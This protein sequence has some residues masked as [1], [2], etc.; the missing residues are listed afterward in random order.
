[1][2][3]RRKDLRPKTGVGVPGSD[4]Y[5]PSHSL[6]KMA[7]PMFS[8]SR[9]KRDGE[10]GIYHN[11]PGSGSYQPDASTNLVKEHSASWR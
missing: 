8:L 6:S 7:N 11:T 2:P 3:G 9:S 4:S 1:M 5:D 10:L